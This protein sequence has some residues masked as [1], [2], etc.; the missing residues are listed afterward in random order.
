MDDNTRFC[1][2]CGKEV[3]SHT[4]YC[5]ACGSSLG[6][7]SAPSPAETQWK[8][9][10]NKYAEDK[11]RLSMF[12]LLIGAIVTL[13]SG[14][15]S[16]VSADALVEAIVEALA[17]SGSKF[18]DVFFGMTPDEMKDM[19]I[20]TGYISILCGIICGI[21]G[22]LVHMRQNWTITFVFAIIATIMGFV[23]SLIGGI[24]GILVCW[25]LY[26]YKDAFETGQKSI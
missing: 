15:S 21:A 5:P 6:S 19:L 13:V 22:V 26:K 24:L 25:Y 11:F 7:P 4:A 3:D 10:E 2:T 23:A 20:M 16:V 8:A 14:I 9:I 12:L 1:T 17:E 18:E